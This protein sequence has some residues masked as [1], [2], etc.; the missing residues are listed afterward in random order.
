MIP[1][2]EATVR[3]DAT[4]LSSAPLSSSDPGFGKKL[5]TGPN[6]PSAEQW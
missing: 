6:Y 4:M 3:P 5:F 1:I 2:F